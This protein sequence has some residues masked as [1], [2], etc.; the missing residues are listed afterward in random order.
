MCFSPLCNLIRNIII[1]IISIILGVV[2]AVLFSNGV[3]P[4]IRSIVKAVLILAVLLLASHVVS[5][6]LSYFMDHVRIKACL[7]SAGIPLLVSSIGTI[8]VGIIALGI[9][10]NIASIPVAIL[11]GFGGF[12]FSLMILSFIFFIICLVRRTTPAAII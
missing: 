8:V 9:I 6:I 4:Y 12:F 5:S 10:L 3:I 2:I 11:I 7:A 1:T